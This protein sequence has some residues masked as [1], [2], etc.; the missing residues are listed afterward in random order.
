MRKATFVHCNSC[1]N[2]FNVYGMQTILKLRP[3]FVIFSIVK[4]FSAMEPTN[5]MG[6]SAIGLT[7]IFLEGLYT[8][9]IPLLLQTAI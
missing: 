6:P 4:L 2:N 5:F 3:C 9:I 7:K 1:I 8:A